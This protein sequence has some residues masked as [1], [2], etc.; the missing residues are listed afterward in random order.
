MLF[1]YEAMRA[2]GTLVT[3]RIEAG[4]RTDAASSLREKGLLILRLDEPPGAQP[5]PAPSGSVRSVEL[6]ALRPAR[7]LPPALRLARSKVTTRDLILFT[8]QMRMLL[9][10]GSPVVSALL[11]VEEQ[12]TKP[13]VK[14]LVRR[15]R[16]RVEKGDSLSR[17]VEAEPGPFDPVFR[18]MIA[19]GETTA[20]LPQVFA[21]LAELAQQR[22]QTRKLVIGALLYPAILTGL[23]AVV[24][25]VLLFFVVP[26]FKVLFL[27]LKSPLPLTTKLLFECSDLAKNNWP[28]AAGGLAIAVTGLVLTLRMP[29]VRAWLDDRFLRLPMVG[30]LLS[31]LILARVMRVWAAML[32][33]HVPLLDTIRQSREAVTNAA[34]L[35][36]ISQV[37]ESVSSGGRIGQALGATRL[38][39]PMIVSALKTGE[40]NGRLAEAA[41]FVSAWLDEDNATAV[42]HLARLVEPSMLAAMG[43]VVGFVAMSL[44]IPL[45]DLATAAG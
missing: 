36:L 23:L 28:Y 4:S 27:N 32:R 22:E 8:R 33:C 45:F 10:A 19:A 6:R 39:D 35:Q 5:R 24:L 14:A 29:R 40:E 7:R 11:A 3:D 15:L 12:V 37:E 42:Q 34:F 25:S 43:L 44:F 41:D 20:S 2:D 21:R 38:A 9:E 18:S 1:M 16:E 13:A 26:R 30:P 17:A 31:R